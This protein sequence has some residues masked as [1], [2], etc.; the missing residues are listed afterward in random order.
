VPSCLV[1]VQC[2]SSMYHW[3]RIEYGLFTD[4]VLYFPQPLGT[5]LDA[6][7]I[8][9]F[10]AQGV[11]SQ[12]LQKPILVIVITGERHCKAK[13]HTTYCTW[14][15][16]KE[17]GPMHT[18]GSSDRACVPY[19]DGE[20]TGEPPMS[21]ANA[22]KNAKVKR[23]LLYF[24]NCQAHSSCARVMCP[25]HICSAT[26]YNLPAR[27]GADCRTWWAIHGMGLAP[28]PSSLHKLAR[29]WSACLSLPFNRL[30]FAGS[31]A[32]LCICLFISGLLHQVQVFC[33]LLQAE[34]NWTLH[35]RTK[36]PRPSWAHWIETLKLGCV[37]LL[38]FMACAA[39]SSTRHLCAATIHNAL[40]L[41]CWCS[42]SVGESCRCL[43]DSSCYLQKMVD[44]TS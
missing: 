11:Q 2:G 23:R 28:W 37:R 42:K 1:F 33:Q 26:Q 35:C 22:I 30:C 10:V 7:V 43:M 34:V 3:V 40:L 20:P 5:Q 24:L 17:S 19:E 36:R 13:L 14:R 15:V 27:H 44:A 38:L 41:C 31:K 16:P 4:L 12:T 29:C 6:K 18:G 9:P 8:R 25:Q 32:L 39:G 21:V